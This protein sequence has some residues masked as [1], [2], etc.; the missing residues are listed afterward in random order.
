[1]E[2]INTIAIVLPYVEHRHCARHIFANRHK[3]FKRDGNKLLFWKVAKAHNMIDCNEAL[4]EMENI[5]YGAA[6]GL[7]GPIQRSFIGNFRRQTQSV[8]S[9]LTKLLKP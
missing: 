5:N 7:E 8:M 1:M 4:D 9:F 6:T 3:S 2:I